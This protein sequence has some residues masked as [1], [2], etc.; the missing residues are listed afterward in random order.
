VLVPSAT[1]VLAACASLLDIPEDPRVDPVAT[2]PALEP[3]PGAT[4]L[5]PGAPPSVPAE[6]VSPSPGSEVDGS[7]ASVI[8]EQ[9]RPS[10]GEATGMNPPS[11]SAPDAGTTDEPSEPQPSEPRPTEPEPTEPEPSEPPPVGS[12]GSAGQ[13]PPP[14][15]SPCGGGRSQGPNGRCFTLLS[16]TLPWSD[17][18]ESCQDLGNGWDLAVARDAALNAFLATLISDEAWLGGTDA[19][20]EGVWRWVDD[21][22]I[23]WRG[24]EAGAAPEGEFANWNPTEPNG[25]GN[26]DCL[27]LVSRV[28]NEWA[29][30]ECELARSALCEGPLP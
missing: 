12:G 7:G 21:A 18:R 27:R 8:A 6:N 20:T 1:V 26:S 4:V 5:Q 28:G 19:D 29:D 10:T 25:G 9:T 2:A 30:L 11:G 17:A 22:T 16:P 15:P 23:F 13:E 3:Q 14:A 24:D